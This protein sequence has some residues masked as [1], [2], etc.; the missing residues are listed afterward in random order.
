MSDKTSFFA[1][2]VLRVASLSGTQ[3]HPVTLGG[4]RMFVRQY[5]QEFGDPSL[6]EV[7]DHILTD[8]MEL[9]WKQGYLELKKYD[10]IENEWWD[11]AELQD[12]RRLVGKSD[13]TMKLTAEGRALLAQMEE[14]Q[15]PVKQ[16]AIGYCTAFINFFISRQS[17]TVPGSL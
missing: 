8:P 14:Q 6:G 15:T 11:F 3:A 4:Y 10:P 5:A 1:L 16:N 2:S 7:D 9:L 17:A 13:W 12:I